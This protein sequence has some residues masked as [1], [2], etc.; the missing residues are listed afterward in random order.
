MYLGFSF[1]ICFV[2]GGGGVLDTALLVSGQEALYNQERHA[3][4]GVSCSFK[5]AMHFTDNLEIK[6]QSIFVNFYLLVPLLAIYYHLIGLDISSELS[7]YRLYNIDN[8]VWF[9]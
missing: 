5:W 7:V 2:V 1:W 4:L 9:G 3:T 8:L 6:A